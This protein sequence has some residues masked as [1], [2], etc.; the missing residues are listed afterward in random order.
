MHFFLLLVILVYSLNVK[1]VLVVCSSES[2]QICKRVLD[3]TSSF[4]GRAD[5]KLQQS[6]I[7]GTR[8]KLPLKRQE[9][10]SDPSDLTRSE[11][12]EVLIRSRKRNKQ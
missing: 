10:G 7:N 6:N 12:L 8:N 11:R 4:T 2:L 5:S 9:V 1:V 3:Q